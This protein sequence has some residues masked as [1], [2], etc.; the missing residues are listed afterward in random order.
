[1]S[2]PRN[3]LTEGSVGRVLIRMTI[4]MIWGI[5]AMMLFNVVDTYFIGQLGPTQ[6]AAI[7]FTFPVVFIVTGS[8][9]GMGIGLSSVVSRAV[10]EGDH[11]RVAEI[12]T[13]GLMLATVVVLA[14]VSIGLSLHDRL[15]QLLGADPAAIELIRRYMVPWF[16]G[17]VFLVIPMVGNSAIR[18]TGDTFT[19]SLVMMLAGGLNVILDPLLIFGIGP[20]P[21][22]EMQGA[23]IATV[24]SYMVTFIAAFTILIRREKLILFE[25][26]PVKALMETW[27]SILYIGLPAVGTNLLVPL[28]NGII[29][30]IMSGHGHLAVA[31]FGVGTRIESLAM[32]G[33]FALS[34]AMAAFAGQNIGAKRYDRIDEALRFGLKYNIGLSLTLWLI[35]S[36]CSRN[37]A[38]LFTD[39][40]DI[41]GLVQ[42]FL[43]LVPLSYGAFGFMLQSAATFNA[44]GRPKYSV[45]IFT[46]RMFVLTV[47]LAMLGSYLAGPVGV[48]VAMFAGNIATGTLAFFLIR[49][50]LKHTH[51]ML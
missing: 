4:P 27:S 10:G 1:M 5:L 12:T 24:V 46:T 20:F 40:A 48:F 11:H 25:I 21:R 8:A 36:T 14:F 51:R 31:A 42:P 49:R 23:A 34:T 18:A 30:R 43:M 41:I 47:P 17:V 28:A 9:M 2:K 45:I 50:A 19:P 37:I 29:T 44:A 32:V 7:G 6:L 33:S 15:F 39:E 38:G 26:P 3:N 35:L 22:L 13:R 16:L